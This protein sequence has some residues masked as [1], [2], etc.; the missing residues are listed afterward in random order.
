MPWNTGDLIPLTLYVP[1][2]DSSTHVDVVSKSPSG[3]IG[4]VAVPPETVD[5]GKTWTTSHL[6]TSEGEWLFTWTVEGAGAGVKF[7][8]AWVSNTPPLPWYPGLRDVA[9]YVPLRTVP[10]DTP[11]NEPL[12]TFDTTTVPTGEQV[13]RQIASAVTW[14]SS[15]VG[16]VPRRSFD[17]AKDLAALRAATLVELSYPVRGGDTEIVNTLVRLC[18][19]AL[20]GL[21]EALKRDDSDPQRFPLV[22]GSFPSPTTVEDIPYSKTSDWGGKGQRYGSRY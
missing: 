9:D 2:G 11:T 4:P 18:A 8:S 1:Q 6:V 13:Y 21:L 3:T 15:Y 20:R 10:V 14:V 7:Y 16:V 12:M 22:A 17:A 5:G 19:D